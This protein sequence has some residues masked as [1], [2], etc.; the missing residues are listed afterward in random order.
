MGWDT[1]SVEATG[2]S[3]VSALTEI[4]TMRSIE[5]RLMKFTIKLNSNWS[6]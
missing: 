1:V 2:S 6:F 4:H 3:S 5:M